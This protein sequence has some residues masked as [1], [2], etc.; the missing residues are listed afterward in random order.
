ML[1]GVLFIEL[2]FFVNF[3]GSITVEVLDAATKERL[4]GPS[5]QLT[6]DSTMAQVVWASKPKP[7]QP[8][9]GKRPLRFRFVLRPGTRVYSFWSAVDSC[10]ASGGF[11]GGGGP[12]APDGVDSHG[13]C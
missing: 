5:E 13:R 8:F 1:Y 10:G 12:G 7:L 11:T 3:A 4:L 6:A 9:A 2:L